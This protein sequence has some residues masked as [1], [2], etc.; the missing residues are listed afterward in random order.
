MISPLAHVDPDAKIGNNVTIHPFAYIEADVEIGDN[1]EIMPYA[2]IM[3]G[4]RMGSNNKVFQGA[5]IGADPQDFRWKGQKGLCLIGNDNIIREQVIINRGIKDG[6][7]T[8]I[9]DGCFILAESHIGHD[10]RLV[11]KIVLGNGVK[12]AGDVVIDECTILSSNVVVNE[13]VKVSKWVFIKG[14]CRL[15]SNVP[16]FTIFA[17]NPV[18]YYGVNAQLMLRHGHFTEDDVEAASKAYRHIYKTQTSTY[19]ALRRIEDDVDDGPVREAIL[20]FVRGSQLHVI[21][22]PFV[23]DAD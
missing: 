2:S 9:G 21:A 19:N 4:T 16:P 18:K 11:G 23:A 13:G 22:V 12:I 3:H 15:S 10:S 14:G 17:H 6:S 8:T 1:C 7:S 20:S 5:V